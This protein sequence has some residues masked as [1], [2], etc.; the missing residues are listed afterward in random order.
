MAIVTRI[1]SIVLLLSL[2][3]LLSG[4]RAVGTLTSAQET[5]LLAFHNGIR[6]G[7]SPRACPE[8]PVMTWDSNLAQYAQTHV[9]KCVWGHSKDATQSQAGRFTHVGENIFLGV[10]R[11]SVTAVDSSYIRD[12]QNSWG[13]EGTIYNIATNYCNVTRKIFSCGH[14]GQLVWSRST[15]VGC[16]A[17]ACAGRTFS[18]NPFPEMFS[19]YIYI[20]CNYGE[21]SFFPQNRP[22][23]ACPP[24]TTTAR[25]AAAGN[26]AERSA[27]L[28]LLAVRGASLAYFTTAVAYFT[29][30]LHGSRACSCW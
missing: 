8:L 12:L 13:G 17:S 30:V 1:T 10:S 21:G 18:R 11:A 16:A 28:S 24:A 25:P 3:A 6:S 15:K 29:T 27:A 26:E 7:V 5:T 9:N 4:N 2:A 19:T 22:Y 23:T 14:Y 20:S